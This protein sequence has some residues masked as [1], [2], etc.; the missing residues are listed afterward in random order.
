[1]NLLYKTGIICRRMFSVK[2]FI[3]GTRSLFKEGPRIFLDKAFQHVQQVLYFELVGDKAIYSV[4]IKQNRLSKEDI[5]RIKIEAAAFSYRPLISILMPVYNIEP[6]WLN[7][8]VHTVLNQFY[9]KW[10]LCI[11]DDAS[12]H[13]EIMPL[14]KQWEKS[15]PRIKVKFLSQNLGISGASN[16]A[17]AMAEGEFVALLDHDDE[18]APEA[19]YENVKLLNEHPE[20]DMIYSDEDKLSPNGQRCDSYFKPDWSPDLMMSCMYTC[21]FGVYRKNLIKEIGG[22]RRGFEGAQ[23]WDLVLRLIEKTG[24]IYHIPKI[25]YHWRKLNSSMSM[26]TEAKPY[27][28]P[29][30]ERAL[31]EALERRGIEATVE[32]GF[33]L[34]TFRVRR[35]I[36]GS[37]LVSIIIP[38]RDRV[39]LL[40]KCVRAIFGKAEYHNY[41]ILIINNDSREQETHKYLEQLKEKPKVRIIDY[42]K[43]FNFAAINNFG[44]DA[45]RGEQLLFMNN[46]I[47]AIS[48]GWLAA[49]LEH[50]QRPEVGA[51]GCKLLFPN[52]TI[53]HAGVIFGINGTAIHHHQGFAR[54]SHGYWG[55]L[56][57]IRNY[58]AVT[59]ACMMVR[60][61]LFLQ[62]GGFDEDNFAIAYNDVDLCL[63]LRER[64]LL[65]VYTP[66]AVMYHHES[67]TRGYD[68]DRDEVKALQERWGH[69]QQRDPYY[70]PN[71]TRKTEDFSLNIR[72]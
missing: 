45:A 56:N 44:A 2:L 23:D 69:V 26:S 18:L 17:L 37:P 36:I 32:Q 43:P 38:I 52:D 62:F 12:T 41:E 1:M 53:Q 5:E 54:N 7:I 42:H 33:A 65:I 40:E 15:D 14:L 28:F 3:D 60:K 27:A 66:Y 8:A 39:D 22:F 19:L 70:N 51:V 9:S 50:S 67:A 30:S 57:L 10:E 61:E 16:E 59:A 24:K 48:D 64:G 13:S 29:A 25:L 21:H 55:L 31:R 4:W 11:V 6:K 68:L 35:K 71:L 47:E 46:D 58:S 49:M 20:A 34:G 63:R 72:K